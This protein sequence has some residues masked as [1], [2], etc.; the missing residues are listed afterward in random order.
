MIRLT[1]SPRSLW[2]TAGVPFARL[3]YV[4]EISGIID[5]VTSRD[6]TGAEDLLHGTWRVPPHS[7]RTHNQHR[8]PASVQL[9]Q[10]IRSARAGCVR[11]QR[12]H[13]AYDNILT[14]RSLEGVTAREPHQ[15]QVSQH[16]H[17]SWLL[18]R[19]SPDGPHLPKALSRLRSLGVRTGDVPAT[20]TPVDRVPN[21][22]LADHVQ[23][24][25]PN[26]AGSCSTTHRNHT[27]EHFARRFQ[28]FV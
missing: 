20:G 18:H 8:R 28:H 15:V 19:K 11:R 1:T 14:G 23:V 17:F 24:V 6:S 27:L 25:L 4:P 10:Q 13:N 22:Y 26:C 9:S 7:K 3:P 16:E 2:A 5:G 12:M 21:A